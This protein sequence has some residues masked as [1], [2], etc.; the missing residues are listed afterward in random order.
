[1][2]IYGHTVI[3]MTNYLKISSLAACA[4]LFASCAGTITQP[5]PYPKNYQAKIKEY[6]DMSL[7]DGSTARYRFPKVPQLTPSLL[8]G[9]QYS[10]PFSVNAKNRYGA[11]VGFKPYRADFLNGE[12]QRAN[13]SP[14][15]LINLR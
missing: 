10:V 15:D 12:V 1:M 4:A 8:G 14:F 2:S 6:M 13:E 5:Q 11:Y 3:P 7:F 9:K